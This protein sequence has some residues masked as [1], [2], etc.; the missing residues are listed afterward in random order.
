MKPMPA[1]LSDVVDRFQAA[2][3]YTFTSREA[4]SQTKLKPPTLQ[5]AARRLVQSKR[6]CSPREGFFVIVPLEYQSAGAPP[7]SWF[8]QDL[9]EYVGQPYYVGLLSAASIH[10]AAHQQP[11]EF[12]VVTSSPLPLMMAGRARLRFVVKQNVT[13]TPVQPVKTETGTMSVSTPEAT[14]LDLIRYVKATG[15][16]SNVATVL[17]E[18]LEK[19]DA[20]QLAKIA[21]KEGELAVAQ[22]L[23]YLLDLVGGDATSRAL[24]TWI[25]KAEPRVVP[26]HPTRVI[27]GLPKNEKW[28]VLVNAD[29][30]LDED[31][32]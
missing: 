5:K 28:R 29:I 13:R 14:A 15:G 27:R 8:V 7:P 12:Q 17:G 25:A 26:L 11:Q 1:S 18:L 10:G 4:M 19:V 23:G 31:A 30:E 21:R 9:M 24:A 3:R 20:A 22:R 32:G 2:G 16:L 6:L